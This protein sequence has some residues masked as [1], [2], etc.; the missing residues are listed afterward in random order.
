MTRRA[1][2]ALLSRSIDYKNISTLCP[3][4]ILVTGPVMIREEIYAS[5]SLRV[6]AVLPPQSDR[7][8]RIV[9]SFAN[10]RENPVLSG[11]GSAE[12][13]LGP[14]GV[15]AVHFNCIGNH[16]WQYE[17][18]PL[19]LDAAR[20]FMAPWQEIVTYGSSMGGYAALRYAAALGAHRAVAGC[21][22][23]SIQRTLIPQEN[24]WSDSLANTT[25]LH[26]DRCEASMHC[27]YFALYD[28]LFRIDAL[29][30]NAFKRH[31]PIINVPLPCSG[32]PPL[33]LLRAYGVVS[34][35]TLDLL[36]ETYDAA[37]MRALHR[38]KRR[39][40]P[41]YWAELAG[42]LRER[43]RYVAMLQACEH[44]IEMAPTPQFLKRA[45]NL[46]AAAGFHD[47]VAKYREMLTQ[48]AVA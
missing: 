28:P 29:H 10:W 8:T 35:V 38:A 46:C 21:P 6:F 18:L 41:Y 7:K 47:H 32:H 24:R 25:F 23:F 26:E 9:A 42:R 3:T 4:L 33:E 22:Q 11:P 43:Q 5:S 19:A 12:F 37:A 2:S 36:S 14:H 16:W 13:L 48:A 27:R 1:G 20:R 44:L 45:V 15:D 40:T 30:V 17:D 34:R 31:L 39:A